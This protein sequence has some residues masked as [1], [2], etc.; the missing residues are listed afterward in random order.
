M[1]EPAAH[2][3][4]VSFLGVY[5]DGISPE[6]RPVVVGIAGNGLA[7][8]HR[9]GRPL[10]FWP[11]AAIERGE[12]DGDHGAMRLACGAARLRVEGAPFAQALHAS[13]PALAPR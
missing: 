9:D 6:R 13:A 4:K 3:A 10:A 12:D 2:G 7:L 8:A 1:A 5:F 11:F